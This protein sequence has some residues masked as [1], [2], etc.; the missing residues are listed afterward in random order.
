M[1]VSLRRSNRQTTTQH[2]RASTLASA[3]L[4]TMADKGATTAD[5]EHR[6]QRLLRGPEEFRDSRSDHHYTR[7]FARIPAE[8]RLVDAAEGM[9]AYREKEAVALANLQRLR[10]ERLAR[11]LAREQDLSLATE[12][13]PDREKRGK[14]P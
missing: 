12:T 8:R 2:R 1:V 9:A 4:D 3:Q 13:R 6:K 11:D 7:P 5:V 14:E 10:T